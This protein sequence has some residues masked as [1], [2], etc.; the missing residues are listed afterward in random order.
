MLVKAEVI[1]W[2]LGCVFESHC[3]CFFDFGY[4]VSSANLSDVKDES[5]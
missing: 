2:F 5:Y 3:N 1:S 4:V